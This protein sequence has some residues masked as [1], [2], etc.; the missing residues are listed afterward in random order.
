MIEMRVFMAVRSD[1][2][3]PTTEVS[4]QASRHPRT[5]AAHHGDG[6][7]AMAAGVRG[8]ASGDGAQ[9]RDRRGAGEARESNA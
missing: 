7:R 4:S 3:E 2:T 5:G 1:P 6:V 8:E 9:R